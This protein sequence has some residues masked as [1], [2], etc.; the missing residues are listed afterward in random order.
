MSGHKYKIG[1]LV[2]YLSR[3]ATSL[4]TFSAACCTVLPTAKR[5]NL[6]CMPSNALGRTGLPCSMPAQKRRPRI[7]RPRIERSRFDH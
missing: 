6:A 7:G 1:Q 3:D 2:S 4:W 5:S